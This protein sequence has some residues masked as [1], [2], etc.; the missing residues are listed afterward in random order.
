MDGYLQGRL[1]HF[2]NKSTFRYFSWKREELSGDPPRIPNRAREARQSEAETRYGIQLSPPFLLFHPRSLFIVPS[3]H[4][5]NLP[6]FARHPHLSFALLPKQPCQCNSPLSR[7]L[8]LPFLL[9]QR[10]G[11][12]I[13]PSTTNRLRPINTLY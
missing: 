1:L 6:F 5:S 13:T 10:F 4:L 9:R 7:L 11:L 2:A 12:N 3:Y 8:A